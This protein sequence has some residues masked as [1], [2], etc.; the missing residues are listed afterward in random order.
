MIKD[1]VRLPTPVFDIRDRVDD[2]GDRGL[3]SIAFDNNF[4]NNGY[5]YVVYTFDTNGQ[6]DGIGKNRLVRFTMNGDVATNET[7]IF[8]SFP[9]ADVTLLY[10]GAVEMGTDGKLY[11]TVGDYLLGV[12][13]Q[14]RNN[15]KGT[16]LRLN[17][18]GTIPTDNPFYNE[19]TGVNRAIY[20]YGLR[21]PWQ[22]AKNPA[23]GT[24]FVSDVG[25]ATAEELNVLQWGAN[26]GW[27][28]AEGP[29][30]PNDPAEADFVD[31]LFHY[32]HVD[33]FPNDPFAG[34]AIIGGSFY[35]TPNPTF[36]AKYHGQYFTGDYCTGKIRAVNPA[37]GQAEAFMDGFEFGLVD[38]AVSPINGDLYYIDQ[39][40][41]GDN[42]SPTG[43]VGKISFIGQQNDITITTAPS[44]V[45]VALGSDASFFVGATAPG[46]ITYQWLRNGVAIPGETNARLDINNVRQADNNASFAV[47]VTSAGQTVR[48]DPAVLRLT[49]NTAP[50]P[51]I[52][53]SG[54]DGGYKA[55]QPISFNGT[56]WDAEDGGLN[57]QRLSWEVRLNH[58]DHDHG[59]IDNVVA[60]SGTVTVPPSIET[61]TNV[62]VTI[63]LTA[64]DLDGT[65]KTVSQRIDPKIVE[66]T[67]ATGTPGLSVMLDGTSRTAPFTFDSVVGVNREISAPATQTRNGTTYTFDNWSDGR[68]RQASRATPNNNVTWTANYTTPGGGGDVCT[69]TTAG[70]GVRVDWTDK[71]GVEVARNNNGWV[72]TPAAG[73]TTYTSANGSVN[74]GWTIRRDGRFDEVCE[75]DGGDGAVAECSAVT[76]GSIVD[77]SWPAADGAA[78][79]VVYRTVN[80]SPQYWRGRVSGTEFSDTTRSGV[81]TYFVAAKSADGTLSSLTE[82]TSETTPGNPQ[83]VASCSVSENG[84]GFEVSWTPAAGADRYVIYRT[85]NASPQY[86]R[87]AVSAP[88]TSFNDT[89]RPGEIE[90]FV[91]AKYGATFTERIAC[92]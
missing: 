28:L 6:D 20:A 52:F 69:V 53:F 3:Q 87:G 38:M 37:N 12:N 72:T 17:T 34:C 24:I 86:W 22:T 27:F 67:L 76:A 2:R 77:V 36:P 23:D 88:A 79:Y 73:V 78:E 48:T 49:N 59:L 45:S 80:D 83:P 51:K 70:N 82:C 8:N 26:Y 84:N 29:K 11:T 41:N 89:S 44:D 60:S 31:P 30:D 54:A 43:G 63:Y 42:Q 61:S 9:D 46:N 75:I 74:D 14:D 90:Y 58:D 1:D 57:G 18:D 19:L 39:T 7:L 4:A 40:L 55:G 64:T 47:D 62:W 85:V 35:S 5:I 21:N 56:A 91:S 92:N 13:G 65:S 33:N 32:R 10:G 68:P 71:Q 50:F 25:D 16:V 81:I 15:I 66:I